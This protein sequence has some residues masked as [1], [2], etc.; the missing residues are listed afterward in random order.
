MKFLFVKT[1]NKVVD[2][3]RKLK[4]VVENHKKEN[5]ELKLEN[6]KLRE[7]I[8]MLENDAKINE[9]AG[10]GACMIPKKRLCRQ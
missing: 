8:E 5:D 9:K 1:C 7:E 4:T 6:E 3:T 2:Y 10:C